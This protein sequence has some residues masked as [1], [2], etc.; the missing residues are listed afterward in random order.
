M[1]D[2]EDIYTSLE[3]HN[4]AW[5]EIRRTDSCNDLSSKLGK[6]LSLNLTLSNCCDPLMDQNLAVQSWRARKWKR[7]R[8]NI[9]W[10]TQRTNKTLEQGLHCSEGT[11]HLLQGS[12]SPGRRMSSRWVFMLQIISRS[13]GEREREKERHG[14][15]S[16][17][18]RKGV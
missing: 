15:P 12:G 18:W 9:P 8:S 7:E 2:S 4:K 14:D 11:G 13:R 6:I 10:F 16:L 3:I 5:K 17:W 1:E